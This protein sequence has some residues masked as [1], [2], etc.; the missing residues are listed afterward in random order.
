MATVAHTIYSRY[1]PKDREKLEIATGQRN[2]E[3]NIVE[4]I[5][6]ADKDVEEPEEDPWQTESAFGA[7][8]RIAA[9]PRFVPAI[10]SYDEINNMMGVPKDFFKPKEEKRRDDVAGWYRSLIRSG[11]STPALGSNTPPV[12]TGSAP[13][14]GPSTSPSTSAAAVS[15]PLAAPSPAKPRRTKNDWFI[16]RVLSSAP[17]ST[18]ATPPTTLA[19][20]LS[21]EPPPSADKPFRPPVFLAIGPSN[22]GFEML[23][24]SGW[25]EGQTLG[26]HVARPATAPLPAPSIPSAFTSRRVKREEETVYV[27]QENIGSDDE[28]AELRK[29]EVVDLTLSDSEDEHAEFA[30]SLPAAPSSEFAQEDGEPIGTALLTPLPTILKSDRLGIGLKAKTVGPYRESKKKIT[31][32]QANLAEHIRSAEEMKRMK[33]IVGRGS[34]GFARMAKADEERRRRLIASLNQP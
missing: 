10:V 16:S 12:V 24:R 30:T 3:D 18:P 29:V 23:Q 26:A 7:Q 27:K 13:S 17:P 22:K 6:K 28:I 20:I 32:N 5:K 11:T 25:T 33:K 2:E 34:K 4:Q 8:R 15:T 31:H 1:D 19:D 9:A 21:R 14:A